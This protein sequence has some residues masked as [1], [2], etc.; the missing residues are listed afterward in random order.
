M[1][2]AASPTISPGTNG[3]DL[4]RT[5]RRRFQQDERLIALIRQGHEGA[6]ELLFNRYQPQLL[7]YCRKMLGSPQD[8]EDVL[9]DVFAAAH[10]TMLADNRPI[11][12]KPWL[13]RIARNRCINH[14]RKPAAHGVDSMDVHPYEH[15]SSTLEQVEEREEL[16]AM[17]TDV[18]ELPET[19]RTA[20]VLREIGDLSYPDIARRMGKS[21]P[22]VKSLLVRARTSLA[23]SSSARPALVPVGLV[24]LLRKLIPAKLGGGSS[25]GATAGS[26][27]SAGGAAGTTSAGIGGV[28]SAKAAVALA[29]AALLTAG[30]VG[31]HEMTA[32]GQRDAVRAGGNETSAPAEPGRGGPSSVNGRPG[33][34]KAHQD[35]ARAKAGNGS[36]SGNASESGSTPKAGQQP[37]EP[38][39]PVQPPARPAPSQA[40]VV[41]HA[42]SAVSQATS[43]ATDALPPPARSVVDDVVGRVDTSVRPVT[44]QLPPPLDVSLNP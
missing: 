36:R 5:P 19:Q 17:V 18:R 34:P 21:L 30:A 6:F 10:K 38:A 27:G 26:V 44:R 43:T 33:E 28:L 20:L 16:R 23:E 7:A 39:L 31:V 14:L 9:Q 32:D 35:A 11:H 40:S 2:G 37:A 41:G 1:I 3:V 25:A 29:S 8:A 15:G 13:Y 4:R 22:S 24:A 42:A 12:A